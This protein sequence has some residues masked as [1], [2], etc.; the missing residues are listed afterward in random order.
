MRTV[1]TELEPGLPS[2]LEQCHE[3]IR[4][5]MTLVE[6][7]DENISLLKQQLQNLMRDKLAEAL[8]S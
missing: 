1:I 8:R 2:E 4:Q 3:L 6:S 5:L 7:K